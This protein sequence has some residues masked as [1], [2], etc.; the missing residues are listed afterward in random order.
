M[1]PLQPR[2]AYFGGRVNAAKLYYLCQGPE[3]IHYM[4]VTSM[5]P[6]VM[7]SPAYFYP[8]KE[9]T[10]LIKGRDTLMPI[11]RVF[12]IMK[13]LIEAPD[14]L[15]FPV[16]PERSTSHNK[17]MYHL[18]TMTGTWSSVEIQKAVHVG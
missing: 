7:S 14:N 4:D 10:I 16:L 12:G 3:K 2:D 13:V 9:P 8:V 1:K 11:D 18:K 17:V 5:F 6:F 15:Y